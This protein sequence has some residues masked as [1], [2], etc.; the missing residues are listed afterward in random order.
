MK[1]LIS[2]TNSGLGLYL[3][4]LFK[5]ES[6]NR[7]MSIDRLIE[8]EEYDVIIHCASRSN[9]DLKKNSLASFI[10]D[11]LILTSDLLRVK[12]NYFIYVSSVGIYPIEGLKCFED[13]QLPLSKLKSE[14]SILKVMSE[15]LVQ[16]NS[17]KSLIIRPSGLLGPAMRPNSLIK[18]LNDLPVHLSL[19]RDSTFNYILHEDV[20][21]FLNRCIEIR[22]EGVY[23]LASKDNLTLNE[24]VQKYKI[25]NVTFGDYKYITGDIDISKVSKEGLFCQKKSMEVVEY[26]YN[27]LRSID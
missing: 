3:H 26:Y 8:H 24:V 6:F 13:Q 17:S 19:S 21:V 1:I 14:Y 5:A 22:P 7:G 20:G 27:Y 2:G 16:K 12:H 11:N 25:K 15:S 18:I 9:R 4:K 10:E 23:N